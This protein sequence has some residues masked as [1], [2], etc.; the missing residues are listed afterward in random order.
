MSSFDLTSPVVRELRA[1]RPVAPESLRQRVAAEARREPEARFSLPSWYTVRR[2]ALVAVPA[3][4][5]IAVGVPLIHG[6]ASSGP[7]TE[8]EATRPTTLPRERQPNAN[9][10][11]PTTT[12]PHWDTQGDAVGEGSTYGPYL[13]KAPEQHVGQIPK[14]DRGAIALPAPQRAIT[15][16]S[17]ASGGARLS[18]SRSRLQDYRASLT[19]RV[20]GLDRLSPSTQKA[21]LTVRALGGYVVSAQFNAAKQGYSELVVRV[22]I[23]R[24]QRAIARFSSLGTIAAQDIQIT[25]LQAR[26]NRVAKQI[27]SIS[28]ALAKVDDK[29]ADPSLSNEERFR[30]RQ[31]RSRLVSALK[32]LTTVKV[33]TVRQARLATISL[34]LTTEQAA[35]VHKPHHPGTLGRAFDDAG[36]IL[37]K[38]VSW[39]LYALVVLGPIAILVLLGLLAVRVSRRYADRRLLESS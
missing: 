27:D 21:M 11:A 5:A 12:T 13:P 20:D 8:V 34:S 30:L 26:Y 29:L 10:L 19:I 1:A 28:L 33:Q 17:R 32:A 4:L 2:V 39:A 35:G 38:E 37:A 18:P 25:D 36:S 7:P 23:T 16:G 24:V 3:C 15:T 14:G 6:I 9:A 31:Q 22:P